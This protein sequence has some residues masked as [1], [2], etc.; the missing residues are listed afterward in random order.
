MKDSLKDFVNNNREAFDSKLPDNEVWDRIANS[1]PSR[2]VPLWD[3]LMVWRAAALILMTLSITLYFYKPSQEGN[4]QA[5]QLRGEFSAIESYYIEEIAEKVAL[6]DHFDGEFAEDQFTQDLQKLDAMYQVLLDEMKVNPS[7][8]VKDA[9]ILNILV[10]MD[11]LD[12]QIK[13]LEESKEKKEEVIP[14]AV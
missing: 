6:I 13:K 7:E 1:L 9:L 8:K 2:K 4:E 12:Q 10:R 5:N 11:L 3:N 14:A